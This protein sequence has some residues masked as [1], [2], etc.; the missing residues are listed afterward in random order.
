[1]AS[2]LKDTSPETLQAY[3]V[4][5]TVQQ[6]AYKIEDSALKPLLRFNN[7]LKGKDEDAKE[8]RWRTCVKVVDNGLGKFFTSLTHGLYCLQ[9]ET[10]AF[11]HL[12]KSPLLR[13]NISCLRLYASHKTNKF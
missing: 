2:I 7:E 11:G 13:L 5:K 6:Y 4:W 3:F 8:E 1:M 12:M 9:S 10:F